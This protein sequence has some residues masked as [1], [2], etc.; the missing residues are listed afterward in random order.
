MRFT[1]R[2]NGMAARGAAEE[3]HGFIVTSA[4]CKYSEPRG[5]RGCGFMRQRDSNTGTHG[6]RS[7]SVASHRVCA[8]SKMR[9]RASRVKVDGRVYYKVRLNDNLQATWRVPRFNASRMQNGFMQMSVRM[10][11]CVAVTSPHIC[12]NPSERTRQVQC[13][14][15]HASYFA[16]GVLFSRHRSRY[17]YI[18]FIL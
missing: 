9:V 4:T 8:P 3:S 17:N 2:E 11:L 1:W 5:S 16:T 15:S 10:H 14:V 13:A 12:A 7:R 18:T 6:R